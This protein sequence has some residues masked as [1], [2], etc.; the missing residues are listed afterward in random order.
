MNNSKILLAIIA[1]AILTS[2]SGVSDHRPEPI[3]NSEFFLQSGVRAFENSD[4][5]EATDYLTKALAHYRSIDNTEGVLLSRINLAETALA[6]GNFQAAEKQIVASKHLVS[7][8]S[9]PELAPRISLLQAQSAWRRGD[10]KE[11]LELITPL[12]P[13][14]NEEQRTSTEPKL[15]TLGATTLRTDIAFKRE[16]PA[17]QRIWLKRLSLMVPAT[18]GDTTLHSARLLRFEAQVAYQE[19]K[20]DKALAKLQRAISHY[21]EVA[22]RPALAATL[23][24][25]GNML[26]GVERWHEADDALQRALY[27]RL[28]IMDRHGAAELMNQLQEVYLKLGDEERYQMMEKEAFRIHLSQ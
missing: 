10:E 22:S 25:L 18:G 3:R 7:N 9:F 13:I 27:I 1:A 14:F 11:A 24:E 8:N 5:V 26:M 2:C 23:T 16:T 12:L 20:S 4:Y 28:W 17:Q 6:A 19:K 15:I 21:R